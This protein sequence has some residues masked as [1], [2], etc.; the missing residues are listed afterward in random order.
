MTD[1]TT[2]DPHAEQP[3]LRA[4]PDAANA[5]L[6]LILVHG[7]GGT[8]RGMI[9]LAASLDLRDVAC[10]AP[11]AAQNT[12]YP[13]SFLAPITQNEPGLTSALGVLR[14][15]VGGLDRAGISSARIAWLGFSQGACL[16]LEFVARHARRYAAI[17]GLSGGVIGPPGTP[18]TYLGSLRGT[19][20]FLGCSD[21]DAHIP[22][23]RVHE[24][25]AVFRALGAQVEEVIYPGMGHLV[26]D[27]EVRRV[28]ALL[29]PARGSGGTVEA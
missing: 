26:S 4:G 16:M 19:P 15:L 6:T 27:D 11:Q 17:A 23:E 2:S 5:R 28:R 25:G 20:V 10:V 14:G 24:T 12:W 29:A 18:R 21:V 22:L 1:D 7:R 3:V 9:D 8:A 13:Y